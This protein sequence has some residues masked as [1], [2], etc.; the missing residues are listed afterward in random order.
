MPV[1]VAVTVP[2]ISVIAVVVA[3]AVA[4][5]PRVLEALR[6]RRRAGGRERTR[7]ARAGMSPIWDRN[8]RP[9]ERPLSQLM[10]GRALACL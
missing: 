8:G 4:V 7:R 6:A 3:V 9:R 1:I 5:L 10:I 2:V